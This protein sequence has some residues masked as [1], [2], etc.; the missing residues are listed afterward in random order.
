MV[1][2]DKLRVYTHVFAVRRMTV[3]GHLLFVVRWV[4]VPLPQLMRKQEAFGMPVPAPVVRSGVYL[5]QPC[6]PGYVAVLFDNHSFSAFNARLT[7]YYRIPP[8]QGHQHTPF[9]E[10][11][12][13]AAVLVHK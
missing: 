8:V 4:V 1:E 12:V 6:I 13:N 11:V 3:S 2:R 10:G 7:I 9:H 5:R